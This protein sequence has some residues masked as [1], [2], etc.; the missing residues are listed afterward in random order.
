MKTLNTI[1]EVRS[2]DGTGAAHGAHA[3]ASAHEFRTALGNAMKRSPRTPHREA[4]HGAGAAPAKGG[5]PSPEL[6]KPDAGALAAELQ[7][8]P[9]EAPQGS[10]GASAEPDHGE[11]R[12]AKRRR[13]VADGSAPSGHAEHRG[14]PADAAAA[15]AT[16]AAVTAPGPVRAATARIAAAN[17]LPATPAPGTA[18]AAASAA[19]APKPEATG[20]RRDREKAREQE[21]A[22]AVEATPLAAR[23]EAPGAP[24]AADLRAASRS[25]SAHSTPH[26]A[27]PLPAPP[28]G[29]DVGGAVLR[30]AAHLRVETGDM[31]AL[32]LHLR[33]REGALHL[34]V[35][36]GAAGVVEARASEL[37]RALASEGLRLAPIERASPEGAGVQGGATGGGG[38]ASDERREAWNE[39]AEGRGAEPGRPRQAQPPR[40]PAA[41]SAPSPT[42]KGGVHVQA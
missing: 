34:R 28:A 10:D 11:G 3:H 16:H 26:A 42:P 17:A 5:A 33:V 15:A 36:G 20:Q 24:A 4:G 37:S 29:Q 22:R 9:G 35:D 38:Q 21:P 18:R 25:A 1:G 23:S 27:P 32:S 7:P 41:S 12:K 8:E 31:G 6:P 2:A 13:A 19:S 39:A 40:A 14:L 30:N